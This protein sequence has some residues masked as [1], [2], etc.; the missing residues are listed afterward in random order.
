[1]TLREIALPHGVTEGAIRKRAKRDGWTR[2]LNPRIQI[3]A[4]EQVRRED[5]KN[6]AVRNSPLLTDNVLIEAYADRI[7]LIRTTHRKDI[8][9]TKELFYT[10]LEE[11]KAITVHGDLAKAM[12]EIL[13]GEADPEMSKAEQDRLSKIKATFDRVM[14]MPSR[15]SSA[16]SLTE[17]LEKLIKLERESYNITTA[18]EDAAKDGANALS[19]LLGDM[20]RSSL[21]IVEDVPFDD[22]L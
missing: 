1:M 8:S 16:K 3:R 7:A 15:I 18:A 22:T 14:S 6:L 9:I 19:R 13:H 12:F 20:R 5:A 17:M 21:P 2:D 4:E 10:L 11:V